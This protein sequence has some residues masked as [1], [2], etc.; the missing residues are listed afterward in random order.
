MKQG[1]VADFLIRVVLDETFR[2]LALANPTSAFAGYDLTEEQKDILCKRDH[3]L[4]RLL[5][6]VFS[7]GPERSGHAPESGP[8]DQPP[9]AYPS[10]P[11]VTLLLRLAP[12]TVET[13]GSPA[14]VSYAASLHPWSGES[15]ADNPKET[16]TTGEAGPEELEWIIRIAPKVIGSE[17][18]GLTVAYSAAMHP[19]PRDGDRDHAEAAEP[20]RAP[21][22][23]PWYHHVESAAAKR[24]AQAVMA[25]GPKE[26][27]GKLLELA[28]ALQTGDQGA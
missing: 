27:Y 1:S 5:G 26:R 25:A 24:A 14:T 11:E 3:R 23:S 12:Q 9:P 18:A 21:S 13:P 22:A 2:E 8:A 16:E 6:D 28:H 20:A 7:Q 10:L 17:E 15:D 19:L 4:L